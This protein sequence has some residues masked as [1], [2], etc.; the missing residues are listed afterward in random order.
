M[1]PLIYSLTALTCLVSA[2]LL[3][4]SYRRSGFRLAFWSGLCFIGLTLSNLLLVLDRIVYP[5]VDLSA[6]RL[7]AAFVAIL[8]LVFGLIWEG[9]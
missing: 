7:G 9:D 6:A 5:A 2:W 8:L 4:R 1:A 3:L